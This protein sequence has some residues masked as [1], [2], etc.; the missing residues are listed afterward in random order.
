MGHKLREDRVG[1]EA[2]SKFGKAKILEY[3][4]NNNITIQFEDGTIVKE[5]RYSHFKEGKVRNPNKP[6]FYNKGYLGQGAYKTHQDGIETYAYSTW[7]RM[8]RRGYSELESDKNPTY[9]DVYV[10]DE[11]HNFQNFAKWHEEN[12][13]EGFSLDKDVLIKGNKVYS[14]ETCCFIPQDVN[15]LLVK[16]NS[17]R[18]KYPI[19][20]NYSK[21]NKKYIASYNVDNK[22]IYIGS[23]DTPEEAFQAYKIKKEEHIKNIAEKYKGLISERVYQALKNYT[24]E[25][26]D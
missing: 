13:T 9:K 18:G 23:F 8:I 20:V 26:T 1:E 19:G 17:I 12:Y 2:D 6:T 5:T 16:A 4:N 25:I 3:F 24:V 14:P 22:K 10:C 21:I 11:W 7:S 15:M